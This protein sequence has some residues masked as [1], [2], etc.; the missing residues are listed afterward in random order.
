MIFIFDIYIILY[1]PEVPYGEGNWFHSRS[2]SSRGERDTIIKLVQASKKSCYSSLRWSGDRT[3][4]LA[5]QFANEISVE[6]STTQT[7][8]RAFIRFGFIKDGH[9]CPLELTSL[10]KIW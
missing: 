7:K 3:N 5:I 8:I 6:A 4:P 2:S 1:M 10:G 9:S